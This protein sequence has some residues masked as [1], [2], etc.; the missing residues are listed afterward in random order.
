MKRNNYR[1]QRSCGKVIFTARKR[2]LG[3]GNIF[4]AVCHS[5]HRGGEYLGRYS[6]GQVHPPVRYT[7]WAGT[8]PPG[9]PPGNACW[10]TVNKQAVRI[11]LECILVSEAC[12]KNSVHGWGG[13]CLPQ[14]MLGYTTP[15]QT[16]PCPV[17]AGIHPPAQCMLEYTHTHPAQC[18]LGYTWL[19]LRTVRIL[20][21]CT[22]VPPMFNDIYAKPW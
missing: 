18:M 21:E 15:R 2:S 1:P 4:A 13:G 6:P 7:P 11:L 5:V 22:L 8:P 17:H 10:G 16:P 20:L 3:Q 14:C 12:V 19:L 9:T